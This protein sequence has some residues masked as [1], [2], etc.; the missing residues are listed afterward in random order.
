MNHKKKIGFRSDSR[1]V[2][3]AKMKSMTNLH[4]TILENVG[5]VQNK[6]ERLM[7]FTRETYV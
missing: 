3:H 2:D 7:L 4:M 6:Q 5:E 1:Y